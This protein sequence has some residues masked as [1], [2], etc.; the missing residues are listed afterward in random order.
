MNSLTKQGKIPPHNIEAE[1]ATLGAVLLDGDV[2][3]TVLRYLRTDDFY[4][5]SHQ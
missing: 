5:T 4:S 1:R 3:S 2:I